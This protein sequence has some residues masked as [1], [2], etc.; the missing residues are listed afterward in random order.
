M[1]QSVHIGSLNQNQKQPSKLDK[2]AGIILPK[3]GQITSNAKNVRMFEKRFNSVK[4]R[5]VLT[6]W[7]SNPLVKGGEATAL[8]TSLRSLSNALQTA[9]HKKQRS[10]EQTEEDEE[11]EEFFKKTIKIK[12][13]KQYHEFGLAKQ[14]LLTG[15]IEEEKKN[16]KIAYGKSYVITISPS[17]K[18]Y[19]LSKKQTFKKNTPVFKA[20]KEKF[21]I[22]E[23][24]ENRAVVKK[25]KYSKVWHPTFCQSAT[26]A[27]L[28]GELLLIGGV[29]HAIMHQICSLT[30]KDGDFNWKITKEREQVLQRYGHTW[31][32]YQNSLVIFGG[33]RGSSNKK[34]T[35]IVLNDLW[36]YQPQI[37]ELQQIT[38]KGCPDLRYGHWSSVAGDYLVIYGG[39]NEVGEVLKDIWLYSFYGK[40]WEKVEMSESNKKRDTPPGMWFSRMVPVFFKGRNNNPNHDFFGKYVQNQNIDPFTP[41]QV[42]DKIKDQEIVIEG[43][44]M[45][46]GITHDN[47]IVNDLYILKSL[48]NGSKHEWEKIQ[49]YNGKAPWERCHHYMGYCEWNDSVIVH[50]GRNN[51][52]QGSVLNDM[53]FLQVDTLTWIQVDFQNKKV[54]NARFSHSW[55][56][57]DTKL[58]IF[59]GVGSDFGMEQS[60]EIVELDPEK[61]VQKRFF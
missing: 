17:Q 21:N 24:Y 27:N 58:I 16:L 51:N 9:I 50:G 30:Q 28:K 22:E 57:H 54:Q 37:D 60:M 39:M 34:T 45:F 32:V 4:T 19:E 12:N 40:R 43:F 15:K 33:Q 29:S 49:D 20:K 3:L 18:N 44:Y 55:A 8:P 14:E 61:F 42:K 46:G 35:R 1:S 25:I 38:A 26:L 2:T 47:E 5:G 6:S 31:D 59:G 41:K 48:S 13:P 53:F 52:S 36:I 23:Q 56:F 11:Q 7:T 10:I